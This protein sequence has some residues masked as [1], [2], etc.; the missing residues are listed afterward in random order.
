MGPQSSSSPT[1]LTR[2]E[3]DEAMRK[4]APGVAK[5]REIR[6]QVRKRPRFAYERAFQRAFNGFYRVRGRDAAWQRSF[7]RLMAKCNR[8]PLPFSAVL[9]RLKQSTS[10]CEASFAS[11]LIATLDPHQPVI[12][13]VVLGNLK[14]PL[15]PPNHPHRLKRIQRIHEELTRRYR[16]FLTTANG[17][18]L[19]RSFKRTHGEKGITHMKMVDF[20]LWQAR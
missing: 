6:R 10:R 11:K 14:L 16:R 12:D 9:K 7:Y 17:K 2:P 13:S 8:H 4:L 19:V 1:M 20:V 18:Y 5:Y 3:I 15:P